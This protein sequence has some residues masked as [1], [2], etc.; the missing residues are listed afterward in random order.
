M[1]SRS[2]LSIVCA[3]AIVGVLAGPRALGAPTGAFSD[4]VVRLGVLTDLSGPYADTSGPGAIEA[5]RMAVEDFGGS[6]DGVPIDLISAD[7]QN[8]ADIGAAILREWFDNQGV[9]AVFDLTSSSVALAA[10]DL[11]T[12][13]SRIAIVS[14]AATSD[15]TGKSCSPYGF[16]WVFDTYALAAGPGRTVAQQA[17][18]KSWFF[19]SVDYTFGISLEADTAKLV[20]AAGGTIVGAVKHPLGVSD[21]SSYL[22]RAQS[23]GA[24][25]VALANGGQD[26]IRSIQQA[27]EFGLVQGGQKLVALAP[28]LNDIHSLGLETAQGLFLTEGFYWDRTE[29]SRAW[30]RRFFE[31][32]KAMP[33]MVQAGVYSSVTHYLKAVQAAHTDEAAAV[34]AKMRE[35][36]VN[37]FFAE[38]GRIREDGRM[39]HDM[40]LMQVKTPAESKG[41]W[42]LYKLVATIPADQTARPLADSEC[43]LVKKAAL[44]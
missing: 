17:D 19:I 5:A 1:R 4:G 37:D 24:Q 41:G 35:L 34:T 36:P 11:A 13:K 40:Y 31:R 18:G 43:P 23:S 8:K 44:K 26:V 32:R 15:L 16:H 28:Q 33:T 42:D 3:A 25:V 9:D 21:F 6:V 14:G 39:V 22:L 27:H 20:A 7:H 38:H 29:A 30:S 10:F 2:L 12:Q